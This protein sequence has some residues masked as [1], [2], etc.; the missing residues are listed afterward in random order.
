MTNDKAQNP[1]MKMKKLKKGQ[2]GF[3]LIELVIVIGITGLIAGGLTLTIMGVFNTDARTRND[4]T[5]V[6]QVRQAGKLVSEDILEADPKSV[7][8]GVGSTGFPLTL[9]WTAQNGTVYA[10][11]YTLATVSGGLNILWGKHY[12]NSVLN[13]TTK[14]AEYIDVTIDPVTA[15]PK[16]NCVWDGKVLTFTV[17][18]TVGGRSETRVYEVKPRPGS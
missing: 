18:A 5:A 9:N 15:K 1:K 8:T 17:T 6:Y 13:F 14:V 11:N 16:T 3:S 10:V 2:R 12:I 7:V 4:M